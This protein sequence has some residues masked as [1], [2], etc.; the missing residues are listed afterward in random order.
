[1]VHWNEIK[2][3]YPSLFPA[4]EAYEDSIP[5]LSRPLFKL[6][7]TQQLEWSPEIMTCPLLEA[8]SF[9][10]PMPETL[11]C[12]I[13]SV[14]QSA[15]S[16]AKPHMAAACAYSSAPDEYS[17]AECFFGV[18]WFMAYTV[19]S[20]HIGNLP[21]PILSKIWQHVWKRYFQKLYA[22]GVF[23]DTHHIGGKDQ[24][25]A[26]VR[27]S[28]ATLVDSWEGL[29]SDNESCHTISQYYEIATPPTQ[30]DGTPIR[31]KPTWNWD[32]R[33]NWDG[34]THDIQPIVVVVDMGSMAR[35]VL[36]DMNRTQSNTIRQMIKDMLDGL[37][38]HSSLT[39]RAGT[40]Q[41]AYVVS[42][43]RKNGEWGLD[44]PPCEWHRRYIMMNCQGEGADGAFPGERTLLLFMTSKRALSDDDLQPIQDAMEKGEDYFDGLF[45]K[46]LV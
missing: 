36:S 29:E 35:L 37:W 9:H 15:R 30:L 20:G 34:T 8:T 33:M 25:H 39:V 3:I 5:H 23:L 4:M 31:Q 19:K 16:D 13:Y 6:V 27:L 18:G 26:I 17:D 21:L 41:H 22:L 7:V 38:V 46:S 24:S 45:W 32:G 11:K 12:N 1:M 2:S 43:V 44:I 28:M 42:E 40:T 10:F 14:L